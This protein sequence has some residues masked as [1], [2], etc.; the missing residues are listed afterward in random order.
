MLTEVVK[1]GII[2]KKLLAQAAAIAT[3]VHLLEVLHNMYIC[4][5]LWSD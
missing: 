3:P 4:A 5:V 1:F 2:S